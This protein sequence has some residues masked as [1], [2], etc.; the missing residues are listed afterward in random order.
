MKTGVFAK[1]GREI[2]VGDIVHYRGSNICAHGKVV[3]DDHYKFA[4]K[5][6]RPKTCDRLYSLFNV[7]QYRIENR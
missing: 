3:E 7:G 2:E 6:D 1:D 4:I 5:D